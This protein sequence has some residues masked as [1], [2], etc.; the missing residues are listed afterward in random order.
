MTDFSFASSQKLFS[1]TFSSFCLLVN[2]LSQGSMRNNH[3]TLN[4]QDEMQFAPYNTTLSTKLNYGYTLLWY[5]L[6]S[7]LKSV[8]I[9]L[10]LR[11]AANAEWLHLVIS[12]CTLVMVNTNASAQKL[13]QS[14][15]ISLQIKNEGWQECCNKIS[16]GRG[17]IVLIFIS[18][19]KCNVRMRV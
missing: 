8:V 11:Q 4:T 18:S 6:A 15:N 10:V 9:P 3:R 17:S 13:F 1:H 19:S 12:Y 7:L 5:L 2:N 16:L 14:C